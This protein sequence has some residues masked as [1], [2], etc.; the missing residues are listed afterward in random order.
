MFETASHIYI[1]V[2]NLQPSSSNFGMPE[3]IMS[4]SQWR[5]KYHQFSPQG[6]ISHSHITS[7]QVLQKC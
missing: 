3:G 6:M 4:E 2:V 7:V 5:Q 1:W